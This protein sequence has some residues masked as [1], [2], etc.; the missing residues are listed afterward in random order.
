MPPGGEFGITNEMY[1]MLFEPGKPDMN[2]KVHCV[3]FAK[4]VGCR[5][6]GPHQ[7][8][9]ECLSWVTNPLFE[10]GPRT[11]EVPAI[12]DSFSENVWNTLETRLISAPV[13]P[14]KMCH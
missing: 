13:K 1:A 8:C 2:A 11:T 9:R 3:D 12:T 6:K 5:V 7:G 4:V 14:V 10:P